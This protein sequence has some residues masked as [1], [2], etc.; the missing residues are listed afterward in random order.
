MKNRFKK[1]GILFMIFGLGIGI[2]FFLKSPKENFANQKSIE[3]KQWTCSMHPQIL[4]PQKGDCP[5]CGMDLIVAKKNSESENF[6]AFE[7]SDAAM[8]IAEIEILKIRANKIKNTSLELLGKVAI[9]K[10][11]LATQTA[12][13]K[14]RLEEF[15]V[16]Y[17]GQFIKK[18][19]LIAK[20]YAPD[21]LIAQKE[22]LT[23][24]P[25]KKENPEMYKAIKEKLKLWK[26]TEATIQKIEQS[27][28]V[29][30]Y[31]PIYSDF[32]GVI[33]EM[34]TEKGNH[35]KK[36]GALFKIASLNTV[37]A[38][39]DAYERHADFFK[40]GDSLKIENLNGHSQKAKITFIEPLLDTQKRTFRVRATLKNPQYLFKL[41]MFLK[42]KL[43]KNSPK[44]N[45][46]IPKTAVLWTGKRSVVYVKNSKKNSFEM[47]EIIL[48]SDIF[49]DFYVVKKG[50][51]EG[52]YIVSKGVFTVD[53]EAQLLGK[54]S[55][56][57]SDLEMKNKIEKDF[58]KKFLNLLEIYFN[59][60]DAFVETNLKKV[61]KEN[62]LFL[63][64]LKLF[65]KKER[66]ENH[67]KNL[68]ETAKK[69]NH[70]K[71][72]MKKQRLLFE[73][74]S[75]TMIALS[76]SI[77][78]KYEIFLQYCPMA[79]EDKGAHWL[80]KEKNIRNP[81][82]GEAMLNCGEVVKKIAY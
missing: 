16:K 43:Q 57:N 40:I 27:K 53:S 41:G 8:K 14:G 36:G 46:K 20:I 3:K 5:I 44:K 22:L 10:N 48:D 49:E 38:N 64:H 79:N 47:R 73:K 63:E 45:I 77:P 62:T 55:M 28:K 24:L 17:K 31:F 15:Y 78:A 1:Y 13:F 50:L 60:K 51:S 67:W 59:M 74:I 80:S 26:F 72:N 9:D 7:M 70:P 61:L 71:T 65:D 68:F 58:K 54:K 42:A 34:K 76:E 75:E 81:Y 56:M 19:Q 25:F 29:T 23:A 52:E 6:D 11:K 4:Q 12:H 39:F 35:V 33:L 21:I 69:M 2:G 32:S 37:W 18:G 66:K 82:F 30:A